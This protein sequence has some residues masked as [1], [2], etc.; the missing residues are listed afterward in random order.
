VTANGEATSATPSTTPLLS[1]EEYLKKREEERKRADQQA[2]KL[3]NRYVDIRKEDSGP[4]RTSE[5]TDIV[6]G[7][8]KVL[9][10][11]TPFDVKRALDSNDEKEHL[12]AASFLWAQPNTSYLDPLIKAA[13]N[14]KQA[15]I[16]YWQ[17]EAIGKIIANDPGLLNTQRKEELRTLQDSVNDPADQ[18]RYSELAR[19]LNSL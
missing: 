9:P 15:F 1:P 17:I 16:Q 14:E 8:V 7:L 5:M 3:L 2:G 12:K 4:L 18:S 10:Y 13:E 6:S 19:I 11:C